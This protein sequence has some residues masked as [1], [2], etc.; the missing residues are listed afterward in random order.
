MEN[1]DLENKSTQ[2]FIFP[3][4]DDKE[5]L[6]I[7]S[8][9]VARVADEE[10]FG[11][12]LAPDGSNKEEYEIACGEVFQPLEGYEVK[13]VRLESVYM[14][15]GRDIRVLFSLKDSSGKVSY[16]KFNPGVDVYCFL[17]DRYFPSSIPSKDE[18]TALVPERQRRFA[19]FVKALETI[20][21]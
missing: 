19:N 13:G 2:D 3:V 16:V 18:K 17:V 9:L 5:Y 10:A 21:K 12:P 6:R 4:E 14:G 11:N 15:G 8:T 7:C 1:T 20:Q